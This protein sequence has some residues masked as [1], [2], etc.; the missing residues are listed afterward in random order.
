M[1]GI[2]TKARFILLAAAVA[3]F[4]MGATAGGKKQASL[5]PHEELMA[6]QIGFDLEVLR[7]VKEVVPDHFHRMSGY[8][9]NGYQI[10]VNGFFVPVPE[11]ETAQTLSLLRQKLSPK[12]YMA[13][14]IEMNEAIRSDKIGFLK[15]ND[16]YEILRV[17][18]TN[19]DDYDITNE[20]II[21]RLKEWEKLYPFEIIGAENDW[22]EIEFRSVPADIRSLAQEVYDFCPDTVEQD[23]GSVEDL[24][25]EIKA[26]KRLLL[27]WD[28]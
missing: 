18:Q 14:I 8:D 16:P 27:W 7:L 13:F 11:Q 17:M 24:I 15:G 10:M 12:K 9:R 3:F 28:R 25:K 22:V 23:A 5:S 2:Y 21:E 1:R 6:A 19:G 4:A 26:T 20:D